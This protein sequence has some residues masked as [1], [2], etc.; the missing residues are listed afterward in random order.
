MANQV[1]ITFVYRVLW[2]SYL[3]MYL[4]AWRNRNNDNTHV[5]D[6]KICD[7]QIKVSHD[8]Y[9]MIVYWFKF[10]TYEDVRD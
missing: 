4:F 1:S 2:T 6:A 10:R 5:L 7:W 9:F 8:R 3:A